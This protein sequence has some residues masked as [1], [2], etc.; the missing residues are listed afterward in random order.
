M[1]TKI[2]I[3]D[4][5]H[6]IVE[7]LEDF[8]LQ[9]GYEIAK[10]YSQAEARTQLEAFKPAI[11]LLDIKLPDGDG[12]EFLK[13]IRPKYEDLGI[14][15]ITGLADKKIALDALKNGASDYIIKPIDL[16]YLSNSVLAKVVTGFS[17]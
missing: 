15:M 8:L 17:F 9:K 16:N 6:D 5:E 12:I 13:Q 7:L 4:D 2:L 14:I 11:M 1:K 10:A 3:V